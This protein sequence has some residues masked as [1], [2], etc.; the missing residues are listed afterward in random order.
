MFFLVTGM[1]IFLFAKPKAE[2][3]KHTEFDDQKPAPEFILKDIGG[4]DVKLSDFKGKIVVLNFWA[5]WCGPCRKEMPDF[6]ALQDQ[7]GKDGVQFVGIALDQEGVEKVK[8]FAEKSKINYP[9]LIGTGTDVADKFGGMNAI[10]VTFLIDRKGMIRGHYIG[11]RQKADLES[12]I[13]ALVS[14][15]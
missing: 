9:I 2:D 7:Y 10:P 1:A 14:E 12:M 3:M 13:L 15:K 6:M 5:T 11:M 4:K 8:P